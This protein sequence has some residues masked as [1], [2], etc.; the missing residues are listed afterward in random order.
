MRSWCWHSSHDMCLHL[1]EMCINV[2][3]A[4]ALGQALMALRDS[5]VDVFLALAQ[6]HTQ[7]VLPLLYTPTVAQVP[8]PLVSCPACKRA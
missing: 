1:N 5:E 4:C 6:Q 7:E 2:Q 8:C 3:A